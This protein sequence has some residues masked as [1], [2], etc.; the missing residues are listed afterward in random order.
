MIYGSLTS[1]IA[2]TTEV[3]LTEITTVDDEAISLCF[4]ISIETQ[5]GNIGLHIA[6]LH[7]LGVSPGGLSSPNDPVYAWFTDTVTGQAPTT[8]RMLPE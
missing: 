1:V 5:E 8:V 6:P 2:D 4:V 3:A 7:G